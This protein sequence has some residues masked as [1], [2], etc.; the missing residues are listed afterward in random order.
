MRIPEKSVQE[1][2]EWKE[3]K[4]AQDWAR[5]EPRFVTD[6]RA[7]NAKMCARGNTRPS[8]QRSD[9]GT[10][11]VGSGSLMPTFQKGFVFSSLIQGH[12]TVNRYRSQV[13]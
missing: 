6:T 1:A 13:S 5:G 9:F 8:I 12:V 2:K 4:K 10:F 3:E 11:V 7:T